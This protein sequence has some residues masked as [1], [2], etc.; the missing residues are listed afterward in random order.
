MSAVIGDDRASAF[1]ND[2]RMLDSRVVADTLDVVHHVVGVLLKRVI[3]TRF[4]VGLRTVVIDRQA[5][6]DVE[7]FE[8][9]ATLHELDVHASGFVECA[10]DV[11]DVWHLA[12]EMEVQQ[13]EAVG[14]AAALQ[15]FERAGFPSA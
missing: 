3:R 8:S 12:A 6:A 2:C 5:A 10:L 7:I 4:E 1:G 11:P 13:L 14:H 15:L 9:R